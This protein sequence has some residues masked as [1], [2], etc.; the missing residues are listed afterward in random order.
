M[1]KR[2]VARRDDRFLDRL[3]ERGR[4]Q[5][6]LAAVARL[7]RGR[8][9]PSAGCEPA[10]ATRGRAPRRARRS[11]DRCGR[12]RPAAKRPPAQRAHE[13]GGVGRADAPHGRVGRGQRDG[14]LAQILRTEDGTARGARDRVAGVGRR[15]ADAKPS[16]AT[17]VRISRV[18]DCSSRTR[19]ASRRRRSSR[20]RA[21]SRDRVIVWRATSRADG[22]EVEDLERALVGERRPAY[23]RVAHA[24]GSP[25]EVVRA[26]ASRPAADWPYRGC[27][28][29]TWPD[30]E[31]QR[32]RPYR[33][34]SRPPI[35][36][37][38]ASTSCDETLRSRR[39][40]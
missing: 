10:P 9:R 12:R 18:A 13:H 17:I 30:E 35:C 36:A 22:I 37:L 23:G 16:C 31:L 19:R 28:F 27:A 4:P 38:A 20:A 7:A 34:G 5:D 25:P 1:T 24:G 14:D 3:R 11:R 6:R 15:A 21:P 40:R 32:V 2:P 33:R 26:T 39:D 29:M 8:R